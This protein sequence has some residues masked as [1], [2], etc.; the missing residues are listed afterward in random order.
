M[1]NKGS[2]KVDRRRSTG[3]CHTQDVYRDSETGTLNDDLAGIDT[4]F[5][6]AGRA[7][8]HGEDRLLPGFFS[9]AAV[10]GL[11]DVPVVL[12]VFADRVNVVE[13]LCSA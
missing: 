11:C 10:V 6:R 3:H 12:D 9:V 2:C 7:E 1:G 5:K 13:V 4:E 8:E